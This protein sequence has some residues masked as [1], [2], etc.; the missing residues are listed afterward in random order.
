M[1]GDAQDPV[2]ERL[3]RLEA[4]VQALRVEVTTLRSAGAPA[5]RAVPPPQAVPPPPVPMATAGAASGAVA[6]AYAPIQPMPIAPRLFEHSHA[7]T[8][9]PKESLESQI[10]SKVLSKVAVVLLL[11]GAALFLKWAFDNRWVG[12]GGRV[13]AGLVAGAAIVL[14]SERFR[15]QQMAAFSYAL[16]AVGSGVLYLS[17]WASFQLYHLV[18]GGLAFAAMVAVTAWNAVMAWSQDAPLLAGYA[19]LG[20]YLTPVLLSSGGDHEVFL[21]SYLLVIMMALLALLAAKPWSLLLLGALPVT[22]GYFIAWYTE[23]F[24]ASKAG[25][26]A[27]FALLLWAAFAVIPLAA[28]DA[29]SVI[30][31]VL[32]PLAAGTFGALTVY[33]VLVDSGR[34]DWEPWCAVGFAAVYLALTRARGR[35]VVAAM[36]LS[37]GVVFLTV[38]IP[39]KASGRGILLGWIVESLALLAI[40]TLKDVD[41]AGRL[42]LR[43][44]G[45][46]ALLLGAVGSLVE[47]YVEGEGLRAFFN[48]GCAMEMGAAAA[49]VVA[50]F[51]SRKMRESD[52]GKLGG[53]TIAVGSFLLLNLVLVVAMYRELG[54]FFES[55]QPTFL[56]WGQAH[57]L[58]DFCFSAWLMVQ[59]VANLVVGFWRRM[60]LARWIGL[61]LL[62]VTAI[63]L[64]TY[65][66]R[67]LGQG[68]RVISYLVLGALLMAVS[69]AYQRD[70][71]GLKHLG[72]LGS[73]SDREAH[74]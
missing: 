73:E 65:D 32:T 45:C 37:L 55:E 5:P 52:A 13:V 41:R 67:D 20:A 31:S 30:V 44:L 57:A 63:K 7:T 74:G 59:G 22:A 4:E 69:F 8:K 61:L 9:E 72:G 21:F 43:G 54:H 2:G 36:H 62:S 29:G 24:D 17:L 42:V 33:S 47:P 64:F 25:K 12:A 56:A 15:R 58:A 49:L 46:A 53:Q 19:L 60:A 16:K 23:H 70:W 71:M 34:K 51:L 39:L 50:I 38:A 68:Y 48:R 27:A 26:T 66:M 10:G 35:S 1:D 14:W 28:K 6:P 18:P 3:A 11:I 40:S